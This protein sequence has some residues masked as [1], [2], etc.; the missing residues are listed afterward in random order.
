MLFFFLCCSL[1][2][3]NWKC[4]RRLGCCFLLGIAALLVRGT[5]PDQSIFMSSNIC[6]EAFFLF[7]RSGF[8]F[9]HTELNPSCFL[10]CCLFLLKSICAALCWQASV[11]WMPYVSITCVIIYVI[12][13]AIG[14]SELSTHT[15]T[16]WLGCWAPLAG[17]LF[18]CEQTPNDRCVWDMSLLVVPLQMDEVSH[19]LQGVW[20]VVDLL[21]CAPQ[22][23]FLM[24]WPPRCSGTRRGPPPSWWPARSTGCPTSPSASF[25]P[26]WRSVS[27]LLRT[28]REESWPKNGFYPLWIDTL[29]II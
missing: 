7:I 15:H 13:H 10:P 14:P 19:H 3:F 25:S 5:R 9:L 2:L 24:W 18:R 1:E 6:E 17:L 23:P 20:V 22:V 8:A 26:S 21:P 29:L 12:G 4:R 27:Q 16:C 28:W 11:T